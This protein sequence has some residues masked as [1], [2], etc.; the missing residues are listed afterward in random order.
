MAY[1]S[2]QGNGNSHASSR[3]SG[4]QFPPLSLRVS[5]S[6][7]G[8]PHPPA[9]KENMGEGCAHLRALSRGRT[10]RLSIATMRA[11]STVTPVRG[12]QK[13]GPAVCPGEREQHGIGED[14]QTLLQCQCLIDSLHLLNSDVTPC[15]GEGTPFTP[16]E[17]CNNLLQQTGPLGHDLCTPP[18]MHSLTRL[19]SS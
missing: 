3:Y 11:R 7:A 9:N 17:R 15:S 6:S 1:F 14:V 18:P 8:P 10:S 12:I 16:H 4:T 19:L 13:Q 5:E 2:V